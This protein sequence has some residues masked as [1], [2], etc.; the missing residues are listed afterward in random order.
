M[1]RPLA[2]SFLL[3]LAMHAAS[4][5]D[6]VQH[7]LTDSII[8]LLEKTCID[9][10]DADLAKGDIDLEKLFTPGKDRLDI[11][12]WL[13]VR[14]QLRAGTMPP[15]SK[16]PIPESDKTAVLSWIKQNEQALLNAPIGSP[17]PARTRR[18]NREEYSNTMRD[19]FGIKSR[20]GDQFPTD[21][22]GGE[23]FNNNADT[24]SISPLLVEKHFLAA[25]EII[26]EVWSDP[27]LRSRLLA[28]V[29]SD[30]LPGDLGADLAL[31]PFLLRALRQIPSE[32]TVQKH[33]NILRAALNR[34]A[35]WDE[36]MQAMFKSVLISPRF[37]F[38]E[39]APAP[40][41]NNQPRQLNH[42]EI[43]TRLSYFLWSTTPDDEL[44]SLAITQKLHDPAILTA[45][46]RR[47]LA[48]PNA[49]AFVKNFAGQWLRFEDIHDKANPDRRK[50]PEFNRKIRQALYD[51]IF[52]YTENILLKNGN[53][54]DLLDSNYTYLNQTLASHYGIP[55]VQ[56]EEF[57]QVKFTDT[58]R[59]GLTTMGGFLAVN[60]YP[61]R[62]SPVL[63]GKWVLEQ[64]MGTSP[65]PPPPDVGGLPED[66]R[67]LK[68]GT[69]RQRLEA[70]R[71]KPACIGCHVR[72]DP[73]GFALE[74]FSPTG[75]WR[76]NENGKPL[77]TT[78]TMPGNRPFT[79]PAEFRQI[80]MQDKDLFIRSLTTRLLGYAL[81]RGLEVSDQPALLRLEKTLRDSNHHIEP[82][83]IA[84]TQSHPFLWRR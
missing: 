13:K 62:T 56:G 41:D 60:S 70:H 21:G 53:V 47:L 58:K 43:A 61:Q 5:V 80:L 7:S 79:T 26:D 52:H 42:F 18:L 17:G 51:E 40:K 8:P 78:G 76:E 11:R 68:N 48:H 72:L 20:P 3:P 14:E 33:L 74:N 4:T 29:Y 57:R 46:T 28:P 6:A 49:K 39:E 71:S 73:P 9:C 31:R 22:S 2:I 67:K 69:L 75:Q 30:K 24:L 37:L 23:G 77:D 64:L 38:L 44:L 1:L 45:Q 35:N 81:D 25:G 63:R 59:G 65:P 16:P 10:H 83:I 84:I 82:L 32:D 15:A 66:D 34:G 19:L 55:N 36:A 54:L 27:P 12:F 50:F